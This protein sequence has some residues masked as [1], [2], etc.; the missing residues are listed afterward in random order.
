VASDKPNALALSPKS[1]ETS[2]SSIASKLRASP[3]NRS[4]SSVPKSPAISLR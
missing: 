4:I 1:I 3:D 2:P